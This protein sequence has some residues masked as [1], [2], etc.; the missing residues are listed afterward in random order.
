ML[1]KLLDCGS[2]S[3][4]VLGVEA[5]LAPVVAAGLAVAA[6]GLEGLAVAVEGLAEAA[7]GLAP[8]AEGLVEVAAGLA[9]AAGLAPVGVAGLGLAAAVGGVTVGGVAADLAEADSMMAM[10]QMA[11]G[12]GPN[13]LA[14]DYG[15]YG[16]GGIQDL[17]EGA[18]RLVGGPGS[19]EEAML[20]MQGY[21]VD[22]DG[23]LVLPPGVEPGSKEY[24]EFLL[25]L[26]A[27]GLI[28]IHEEIVEVPQVVVE[29]RVVH[30]P[31]RKQIQE[32]LIEVPKVE[33]VERV[34]YEDFVEYREVPVDKIIEVPEIEYKVKQ[35]D[36]AVPQ[37]YVQEHFVD[38]YRE[39]P[40]TQVQEVERTEHVPVMVPR[41]WQPPNLQ[42]MG[43]APAQQM[44]AT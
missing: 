16:G 25:Q 35:V 32:R 6:A 24:N 33:W 39:V 13:G 5:G 7:A 19:Y 11:S 10:D 31:G 28:E 4:A 27:Q 3:G 29:E 20:G 42:A 38:R 1:L 41:D 40:V 18:M 8:A 23:E 9:E 30:V 34:E 26:E 22:A 2:P 44:V 21:G 15:G 17:D 43:M 37:T 12:I 36:Q 14:I